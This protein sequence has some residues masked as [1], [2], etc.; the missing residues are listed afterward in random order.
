[1][2]KEIKEYI[3]LLSGEHEDESEDY[4]LAWNSAL[5]EVLS[6]VEEMKDIKPYFENE[7][8]LISFSSYPKITITKESFVWID[9][10]LTQYQFPNEQFEQYK[11]WLQ[12]NSFFQKDKK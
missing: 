8:T 1:M 10:S 9:S 7:D 3:E 12:L 4:N 6:Y 2:I 5:C 11:S